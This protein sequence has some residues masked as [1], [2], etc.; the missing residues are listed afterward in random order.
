MDRRGEDYLRK[1]CPESQ[2]MVIHDILSLPEVLLKLYRK[3]VPR[4]CMGAWIDHAEGLTVQALRDRIQWVCERVERDYRAWVLKDC[5]PPTDEEVRM[6]KRG[7]PPAGVKSSVFFFVIR[8]SFVI[9]CFVIREKAP[10]DRT[11]P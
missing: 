8:V 3:G 7:Q 11:N 2:Y 1:M 5:P 10:H 4:S 9:G 6:S